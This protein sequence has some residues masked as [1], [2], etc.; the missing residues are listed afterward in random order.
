MSDTDKPDGETPAE[1]A[2][3]NEAKT[4]PDAP[5]GNPAPQTSGE[6][7]DPERA[8]ATITKLREQEKEGRKAAKE[9]E[10]LRAK[11]KELEDAQLSEQ[12]KQAK[13]LAELES[14]RESWEREKRDTA[15]LLAA[16]K[17]A[18]S[19]GIADVD[20]AILALDR[21]KVEYGKDGTPTNLQEALEALLDEKPLLKGQPTVPASK[22]TVNASEG[23]RSSGPPPQLT[24]A[25]LEM[26]KKLGK[27]PDEYALWKTVGSIDDYTRLRA[28]QAAAAPK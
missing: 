3:S 23:T 13:R 8:M 18:P 24:A 25:E 17:L 20:L 16:H 2:P 4:P 27:T 1:A 21:T 5:T 7:W 15:L 11:L 19:L 9:A 14:E 6:A 12:E 28:Q 26:A 10:E 22:P